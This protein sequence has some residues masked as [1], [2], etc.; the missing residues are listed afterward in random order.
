MRHLLSVAACVIVSV[1][2]ASAALFAIAATQLQLPVLLA[3]VLG[4]VIGL[5]GVAAF[6]TAEILLLQ[7]GD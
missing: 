2:L 3:V 7:F 4:A 6:W 5:V 1:S